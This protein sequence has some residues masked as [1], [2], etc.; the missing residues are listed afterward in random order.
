[1]ATARPRRRVR[2]DASSWILTSLAISLVFHV[3]LVHY[4]GG[5][6]IFDVEVFRESVTDW[7]SI[8][9][10]LLEQPPPDISPITAKAPPPSVDPT[11]VK[12]EVVPMTDPTEP[13]G[14]FEEGPEEP[15]RPPARGPQLTRP[16]HSK[17][18]VVSYD[19]P[20]VQLDQTDAALGREA[21]VGTVPAD[22]PGTARKGTRI[23]M[24]GSPGLPAPPPV[25][26]E[27]DEVSPERPATDTHAGSLAPPSIKPSAT[28]AVLAAAPPAGIAIP[29][30]DVVAGKHTEIPKVIV[31]PAHEFPKDDEPDTVIELADE[32][33][34]K[35]TMYAEPG[36]RQAYF[37]LEIAVAKRDRLPVIPK[38]VMF[39]SD[40]SLSMRSQEIR[41]TRH[42]VA[43]YLRSL[44]R[45]DRFNVVVFSEE[46]R[47]LFPDFVQPTPERIDAVA[48][49]LDRI[50][51]QVKTDVYR[52]LKAVVRDVAQQS[53]RNRPTNIFFVSDGR[54][55][56][57]IRDAR[58]IVNEIG[59]YSRSNFAIFPFDTGTRG[60]RYLLDLLA[61]R[62]RGSATIADDVETAANT[63]ASLF[64]AYDNPV[65]MRLRLDYTNLDVAET[66]PAFLPNLYADKPIVIYGRCIPGQNVTI[67]LQGKNPYAQR[68]LRYSHTP[69]APDPAR[70]DIAREWAA[71]KIHHIVSDMA[72]VGETSEL[73]AEIKRLGAKFDVRT[74]YGR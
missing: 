35:F 9:E 55:T 25:S 44:R 70:R 51:G 5:L 6:R 66:Y 39:I 13:A 62:S 23:V 58:R 21:P 32:V 7:F 67:R 41:I 47:K 3:L 38:D 22:G 48:G 26:L 43:A 19:G 50:P 36:D 64:R 56:S 46:P 49:F 63:Q 4:L 27:L 14:P 61:Y 2:D 18:A 20:G 74:P 31:G 29:L 33:A 42:A 17:V 65:L 8:D 53:I 11:E 69:G 72:R 59:A 30:E 54:S 28:R 10:G 16:P 57:G 73:K 40:V 45:T 37:R 24:G 12:P 68:A 1:M 34:V 15:V 71:R 52:V 60:N